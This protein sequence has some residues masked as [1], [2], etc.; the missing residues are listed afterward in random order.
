MNYEN[1]TQ[2]KLWT[3]P[4][5]IGSFSSLKEQELIQEAIWFMHD[6]HNELGL[7]NPFLRKCFVTA[8]HYFHRY[9]SC[10]SIE[11]C[12]N[13]KLFGLTCLFL[14]SKVEELPWQKHTH[15][16]LQNR[17]FR[18]ERLILNF[19][20]IV[21]NIEELTTCEREVL[22]CLQ[23]SLIVHQTQPRPFPDSTEELKETLL[24]MTTRQCL[25]K[26]P[27]EFGK[28]VNQLDVNQ[29]QEFLQD[30]RLRK[31]YGKIS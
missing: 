13:V 23:F 3:F 10:N 30:N 17:G 19:S 7:T 16:S 8:T 22:E 25:V 24:L 31:K 2:Y 5:W 1:S 14:A 26:T 18:S 11:Q 12:E 9:F 29:F 15:G 6:V 21:K 28:V 4:N 20:N 27:E